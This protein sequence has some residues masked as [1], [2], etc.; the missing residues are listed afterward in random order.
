MSLPQR[1]SPPTLQL[2]P[3]ILALHVCT[4]SEAHWGAVWIRCPPDQMPSRSDVLRIRCPPDQMSSGSDALQIRCPP[5]CLLCEDCPTMS[6][7]PRLPYDVWSAK[8]VLRRLVCDGGP[9]GRPAGCSAMVARLDS[10]A[11]VV[12]W[13]P[14]WMLGDEELVCRPA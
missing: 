9:L 1:Y 5:T 4:G 3:L 6:G 13:S 12:S 8:A 11:T 7:L 2:M 14:G 10:S